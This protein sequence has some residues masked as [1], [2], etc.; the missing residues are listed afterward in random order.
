MENIIMLVYECLTAF[1]PFL[2]TLIIMNVTYKKKGVEPSQRH[3]VLLI[4]FAVYL[5]GVFYFTGAG[6]LWDGLRYKFELRATRINLSPFSK[7]IDPAGYF[8]NIVLLIPFGFL[9]PLIWKKT[10]KFRHVLLYGAAF[11]LLIEVSQLLNNRSTDIDDLILNTLGALIGYGISEKI[12]R[13][14]KIKE[15]QADYLRFEILIYTGA[16][17]AGRFLLFNDLGMAK[18]LYGF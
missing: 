4:I 8:L 3:V 16:M 7:Q 13:V 11:S 5:T 10:G 17:F 18:L 12:S 2:I 14:L 6:T 1:V 15:E 9:V